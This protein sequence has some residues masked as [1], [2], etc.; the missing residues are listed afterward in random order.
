MEITVAGVPKRGVYQLKKL[1]DFREDLLFEFK[2]TG[3]NLLVY[4]ENQEPFEL[5]DY[6]GNKMIVEDKSGCVLVPTTYLLG[7]ADEYA[8][9]ISDYS[10]RRA[11]Y[12]KEK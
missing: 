7:L 4:S 2:N 11:Y 3:K 10:S 1:E 12:E 6:K 8:E 9:L 5:A